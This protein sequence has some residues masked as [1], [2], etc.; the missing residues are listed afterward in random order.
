MFT[1]PPIAQ[2]NDTPLPEVVHTEKCTHKS[3]QSLDKGKHDT[4]SEHNASNIDHL[5]TSMNPYINSE[6]MAVHL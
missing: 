1:D 3:R 6:S 5:N 2:D 4:D